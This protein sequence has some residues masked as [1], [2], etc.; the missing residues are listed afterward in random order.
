MFSLDFSFMRLY[1]LSHQL[2]R[3]SYVSVLSPAITFLDGDVMPLQFK[4]VD[5]GYRL[6]DLFFDTYTADSPPSELDK[7][8]L[9]EF[10][11]GAFAT[12]VKVAYY[13]KQGVFQ[14]RVT[15]SRLVVAAIQNIIIGLRF[16]Y[17]PVVDGLYYYVLEFLTPPV[18]PAGL[19]DYQGIHVPL[20]KSDYFYIKGSPITKNEADKFTLLEYR[21]SANAFDC[22]YSYVYGEPETYSNKFRIPIQLLRP[23]FK[24]KTEN[25]RKSSGQYIRIASESEKVYSLETENLLDEVFHEALS[26][27]LLHDDF[28]IN[29]GK[30]FQ[31]EEYQVEYVNERFRFRGKGTTKVV[32]S[33]YDTVTP[34]F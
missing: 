11:L 15:E 16:G 22:V 7:S 4:S 24:S 9:Q 27:A 3:E 30:Y 29:G 33:P 6:A 2:Q 19:E 28:N 10:F 34:R 32:Q 23:Q 21:N 31:N 25:Y 26:I 13:N 1:H 18:L 17:A 12:N 8:T 5:N 20:L 14:F